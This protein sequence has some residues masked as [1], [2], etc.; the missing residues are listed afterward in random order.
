M[1]WAAG[2][3]LQ[4]FF[5]Y[6]PVHFGMGRQDTDQFT[7]DRPIQFAPGSCILVIH[8]VFLQIGL[9]DESFFTYWEDTDL[10]VRAL[11]RG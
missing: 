9:L 6:R 1:I 4:R 5:G 2:G 8:S 11:K 3:T 7:D 10:L